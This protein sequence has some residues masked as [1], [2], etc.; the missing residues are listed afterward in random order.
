MAKW[1]P[2]AAVFGL[3]CLM[4]IPAPGIWG[5]L[6]GAACVLAI[7]GSLCMLV[8][9]RVA[10]A[11]LVWRQRVR[12]RRPSSG[13]SRSRVVHAGSRVTRKV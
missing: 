4:I 1:I 6:I 8:L 11:I 3:L 2:G 10:S 12:V 9:D 5:V 13:R 7:V